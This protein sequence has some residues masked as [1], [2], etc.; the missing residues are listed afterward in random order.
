VEER[1]EVPGEVRIV[2]TT[3]PLAL[4]PYRIIIAVNRGISSREYELWR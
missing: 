4:P 3:S 1:Q 2:T